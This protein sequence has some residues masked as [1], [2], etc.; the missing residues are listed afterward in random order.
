MAPFWVTGPPFVIGKATEAVM[1][2]ISYITSFG[3]FGYLSATI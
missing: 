2:S 1:I 3:S